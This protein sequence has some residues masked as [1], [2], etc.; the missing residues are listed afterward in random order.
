MARYLL[1]ALNRPTEGVD[2]EAAFNDWYDNIH[3]D[4]LL[5]VDGSQ[6][7]RRFRI[8]QQARID[9]SY[10]SITEIEADDPAV[11]MQQ[12]GERASAITDT[13]DRATSVFVLAEELPTT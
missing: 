12:L 11:V 4:E 7:V 1:I 3:K 2:D 6:S 9:Q 8:V 5:S 10:V 13:M